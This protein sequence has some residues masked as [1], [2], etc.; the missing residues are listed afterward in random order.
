MDCDIVDVIHVNKA[1]LTSDDKA[2]I[3]VLR[4]EIGRNVECMICEF[5]ARQR[6]RQTLYDLV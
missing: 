3:K 6:K 4:V 5:P 2:L 1:A